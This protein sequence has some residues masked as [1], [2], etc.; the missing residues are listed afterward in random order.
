MER[1]AFAMQIKEGRMNDYRRKLGRIWP[2]LTAFLDTAQIRNFSIW[3]AEDLIFG[4][5]E[6]DQNK[7]L[8][9]QSQATREKLISQLEDTFT[10][11]SVPG[12]DM[13]LMYYNYGVVRENKEMIRHRVFVTK[14]RMAA[15]RNIRHAMMI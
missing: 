15:Q 11:L 14:L 3:N 7:E 12:E 5:Y 4:Y 13:R 9:Q 8:D 1:H 2:E 10:W 6:K